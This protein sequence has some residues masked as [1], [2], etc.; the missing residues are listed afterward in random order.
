[1]GTPPV[2]HQ[3]YAKEIMIL[4]IFSDKNGRKITLIDA[5]VFISG[6]NHVIVT[7]TVVSLKLCLNIGTILVC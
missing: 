3:T 7:L 2:E 4:T 5:F 1:M 6:G